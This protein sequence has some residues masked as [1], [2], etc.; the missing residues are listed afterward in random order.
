MTTPVRPTLAFIGAVVATMAVA[1]T[2]RAQQPA[3]AGRDFHWTGRVAAGHWLRVRNLSGPV[4]V[5]SS[6]SGQIEVD[7]ERRGHG[8]DQA[9]VRFVTRRTGADSG[10]MLICALWGDESSCDE[11]GYH[12]HSHRHHGW[13]D[14]D[15]VSVHFTIKLPAGINVAASTVNGRVAVDG[16]TGQVDAS[17]VNGSVEANT[18]GGPVTAS[19]VNGDV[20]VHMASTGHA[21][22][23]DYSTVNGSVTVTLPTKLDANVDLSTV[24]GNVQSDYPLTLEGRIDPKHLHGTIGAGGLRIRASTVNGQIE[25]RKT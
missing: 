3:D 14:N 2:L 9:D 7:G 6:T 11:S 20:E 10:D 5:E 13:G 25:L 17:T 22:S 24:N 1:P 21:T 16:A 18:L 23:L 4:L 19:T 8:G 12:S 15:D